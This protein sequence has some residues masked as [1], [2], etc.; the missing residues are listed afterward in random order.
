MRGTL[1]DPGINSPYRGRSIE[2]NIRMF[3]MMKDGQLPDGHCVLRAKIDM[4]SPNVNMRDP[5]LYRIVRTYSS[6]YSGYHSLTH[7]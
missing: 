2:E 7:C 6:S 5:A 1:T 4:T 3:T